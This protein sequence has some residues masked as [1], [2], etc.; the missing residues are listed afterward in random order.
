MLT[1]LYHIAKNLSKSQHEQSLVHVDFGEPGLSTNQNLLVLLGE[2][3]AIRK[4]E[5]LLAKDADSLWTLKKGNFKF[6]PAVRMP[7]PLI[8]F[9]LDSVEWATLKKPSVD[10]LRKLISDHREQCSDVQLKSET[11]QA[12]RI[13]K[14]KHPEIETLTTLQAFAHRFLELCNNSNEISRKL[15]DAIDTALPKQTDEKAL[16]TLQALLCGNLKESKNKPPSLEFKV[17]IIF[18]FLP[19]GKLTGAL[20]SPK[21]KRVILEC[22]NQE[23]PPVKKS[24]KNESPAE[25]IECALTGD[26]TPLLSGPYADWSAKPI[27]GKPFKPFSKFADASCNFRYGRADSEG[28][29][30]GS[31]T[32]KSLVA[33]GC[34]I[35]APEWRGKTWD[36]IRNGKFEERSG[37][38][39]ET[40]DVIIAYP[41]FPWGD[42]RP[43]SVFA[44]PAREIVADD[45]DLPEAAHQTFTQNAESFCGALT[46][47]VAA[48][49]LTSDFIRILVLRQISPGQVQLAYSETPSRGHFAAAIK[50]WIE[51]EKNLPPRLKVLLPSKKT[52]SGFG[53]FL[54][55]LLYPDDAIRS[56]SHQ[57]MRDGTE[58][59]RVQSPPASDILDVFLDKEGVR[60]TTASRLLEILIP[61]IEPLIIG[62]GNILH[63][64]DYQSPSGWRDFT[65]KTSD[66]KPDKGKPDPRYHLAQSLSL[67][68]SL[69]YALNSK[70][71]N[72]MT[73][74][75]FQTGKLLA[76]MDELHKC[77]CIAIRDGDIPP[78]LIGNGLL[79]RA[80]DS[81]EQA[82][83]E[84]CERSR[85]YL[86][87]AKSSEVKK[88]DTEEVKIAIFSAKKLLRIAMPLSEMLHLDSSLSVAMTAKAKAH[89]FLGYLSPTLGEKEDSTNSPATDK[90]ISK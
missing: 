2:D 24:C 18:D 40:S 54:P 80:A 84:L 28:F 15:L 38:K 47:K 87:W 68:G 29:A 35:T 75:A 11:D 9:P 6:F 85:I 79:G 61:R 74:T 89:L 17:Q 42:L 72:Y 7:N 36:S 14:W 4:I 22:L 31:D 37:K 53:W 66:G 16:K 88:T 83:A 69:L 3:G 55:N 20:Y 77:Y 45:D 10:R 39:S 25:F 44:R 50:N 1:E 13:L 57:W 90:S 32:A 60:E 65:A 48:S 71:I 73:E 23:K 30:I 46:K 78:T 67:V 58:S 49:E 86:G 33:A 8:I 76:I 51:S 52:E 12:Q 59:T 82:L 64:I 41:S 19:N 21:I 56:L 43:V 70:P 26:L 27:I 34:A 63:R 62:A 5:P 81:P